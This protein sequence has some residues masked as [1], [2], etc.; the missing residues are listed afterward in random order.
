MRRYKHLIGVLGVK[1]GSEID[2]GVENGPRGKGTIEHLDSEKNKDLLSM[3]SSA[4]P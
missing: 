1:I 3:E 2:F 4:W